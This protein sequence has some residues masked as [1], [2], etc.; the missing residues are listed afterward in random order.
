[1]IHIGRLIYILSLIAIISV[2][3]NAYVVRTKTSTQSTSSSSLSAIGFRTRR[4]G[5]DHVT[6]TWMKPPR[7]DEDYDD[8]SNR[9]ELSRRDM[10]E[11]TTAAAAAAASWGVCSSSGLML[12]PQ[13]AQA[14]AVG[15][16]VVVPKVKLG[17]KSS[18]LEVSRTIQGYWQLAGGHGRY[19]ESDAIENMNAHYQRGITTIDTADIYGPSELIIGKYLKS[20]T[21]SSP[22]A[23]VCTK[24]CC[25]R[26]LDVSSVLIRP[27]IRGA[28]CVHET[29]ARRTLFSLLCTHI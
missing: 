27:T 6:T 7:D 24:F 19:T 11:Q 2:T 10:W 9:Y 16:V 1:M 25:F 23:T 20:S 15:D 28:L 22:K 8:G 4:K 17:G 13:P 29:S 12:P 21:T 18:T 3:T 5:R 14:A 26:F